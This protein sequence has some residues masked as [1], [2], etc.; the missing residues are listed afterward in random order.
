MIMGKNYVNG[1]FCEHVPDFSTLNPATEEEIGFFKITEAGDVDEAVDSAHCAFDKW[2]ELSRVQ[3]S[4]YLDRLAQL[5]KRDHQKLLTAISQETGKTLNESHAEVIESLH[6]VQY[7][8]GTGRMP[9][10]E[11]IASEIPH[12]DSYMLR[13]PKGVVAIVSPWNFPMAIG[14]FWNT[15]P[16]LI[17]GNTVVWKPSEYTPMCA[18]LVAELYHEAGFP[19]GV[20]NVIHGMGQTGAEL[21]QNNV[22]CILFTGSPEVGKIIRAHC[23]TTW[24]KSS[25]CEMGGKSAI[26]MFEDANMDLAIDSCI[27][28]AYK[29]TG[30][31]CVSAG[32][33]LVHESII[34]EFTDRFMERS[35]DLKVGNPFVEEDAFC[36]PIINKKQLE[37]VESYNKMT[38]DDT[39][40]EV[41]LGGHRFGDQGYF[42]T[43]HVYACTW[44]R[45]KRFLSEEVFGP[46]VAIIPFTDVDEAIHINNDTDYGLA[47]GFL[48]EN[49]K[50][51]RR[52]RDKLDYGMAY[53]NGGSIAA[54]SHLGF[55][56]VKKSGNGWPSAARCY[57]AVTDE[58]AFTVNHEEGLT[59]CQGMKTK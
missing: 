6:M 15:A 54:E 12:K 23:A 48:T 47:V 27:A 14:G 32:R 41:M 25:A 11:L 1:K 42:I 36:G 26:I 24:N 21:V 29:L 38:E 39:D 17:E 49:F 20:F 44:D 19:P 50:T 13:K 4:D 22:D 10:G 57:Q 9:Y 8:A 33:M 51:A 59:F 53:W 37:R 58:V 35:I 28:S 46:H 55:G 7:A 31:R 2:R 56:G 45:N 52:C 5:M 18:Q 40:V 30:Q 34:G 3:R 16:A 43:P